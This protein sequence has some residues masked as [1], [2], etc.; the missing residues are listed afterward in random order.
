MTWTVEQDTELKTL[1]GRGLSASRA[2]DALLAAGVV[3]EGTS[4]NAVIGRARRLGLSFS[5]GSSGASEITDP[6]ARLRRDALLARERDKARKGRIREER[7]AAGLWG[8]R[9]P[10]GP[11][12]EEQRALRREWAL[13]ASAERLR[14]PREDAPVFSG[15]GIDLLALEGPA[16]LEGSSCRWPFGDPLDVEAFR[17]CGGATTRGSYCADHGALA[18]IAPKRLNERRT[19]A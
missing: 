16:G 1:I 19:R 15:D 17:Y 11:M 10:R 14:T 12:S 18:Y 7:K 4:R 3:P 2:R 5:G 6:E 13:A 9:K 8:V